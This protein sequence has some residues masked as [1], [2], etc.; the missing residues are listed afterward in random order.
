[1]HSQQRRDIPVL[2]THWCLQGAKI[3]CPFRELKS[4]NLTHI[5]LFTA[6]LRALDQFLSG[7]TLT[8]LHTDGNYTCGNEILS[9]VLQLPG[10]D[11]RLAW[12]TPSV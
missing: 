12:E 6:K 8:G 7:L 11:N 10:Q 2:N 5:A 3:S 9:K 1:M 4:L